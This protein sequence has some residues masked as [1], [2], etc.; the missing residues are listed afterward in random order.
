MQGDNVAVDQNGYAIIDNGDGTFTNAGLGVSFNS[1]SDALYAGDNVQSIALTT[2]SPAPPVNPATVPNQQTAAATGFLNGA[3]AFGV[4]IA[5]L[6]SGRPASVTSGQTTYRTAGVV[7]TQTAAGGI[8]TLLLLGLGI[9][10]LV[11]VLAK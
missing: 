1:V 8:G 2:T 10:I 11:K 6:L 5:S 7:P 3:G 4:A 9:L